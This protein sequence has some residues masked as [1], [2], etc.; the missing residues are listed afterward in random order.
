MQ[1][2][3]GIFLR[4]LHFYYRDGFDEKQTYMR[5]QDNQMLCHYFFNNLTLK[6]VNNFNDLEDF[7]EFWLKVLKLILAGCFLKEIVCNHL[8]VYC[9]RKMAQKKMLLTQEEFVNLLGYK[10]EE[11]IDFLMCT[12]TQNYSFF[13]S[14]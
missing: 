11:G 13:K 12:A 6:V 4:L 5:L 7:V 2:K 1:R 14:Q 9:H 3:H 8:T 10:T